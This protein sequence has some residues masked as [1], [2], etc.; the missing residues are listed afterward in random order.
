MPA[1]ARRRPDLYRSLKVFVIICVLL[2]LAACAATSSYEQGQRY[3]EAG[4]YGQAIAAYSQA[5]DNPSSDR[6]LFRAVYQRAKVYQELDQLEE[7]FR[8][9]YAAKL[10]SCYLEEQEKPVGG[11][12]SGMIP[13]T[14]CREWADRNLASV[15]AGIGPDRQKQ[16][17]SQAEALVPGYVME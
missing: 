9:F 4:E 8:D 15:S 17:K 16:L 2:M 12:A 14:Y 13:S 3:H 5:I 7:A 10:V 6:E 11:Y 1:T